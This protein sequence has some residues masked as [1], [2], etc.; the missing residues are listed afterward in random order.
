MKSRKLKNEEHVA[1]MRQT[2]KIYIHF[3]LEICEIGRPLCISQVNIQMDFEYTWSECVSSFSFI[4]LCVPLLLVH[5]INILF[6]SHFL[7]LPILSFLSVYSVFINT[8]PLLIRVSYMKSI[9]NLHKK[10]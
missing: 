1:R 4:A 10:V 3:S 8:V 9:N 6:L 5:Y 2:K 7:L